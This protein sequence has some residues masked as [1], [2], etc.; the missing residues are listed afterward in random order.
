[1]DQ[2]GTRSPK[3]TSP[4]VWIILVI[5]VLAVAGGVL[6]ILSSGQE[7]ANNT[8]GATNANA[9]ANVNGTATNVDRANA[10]VGNTNTA[11]TNA[12]PYAGWEMYE[13][14]EVG[15]SLRYPHGWGIEEV[16]TRA[17]ALRSPG[18][19]PIQSG[20]VTFS[21]D[22]YIRVHY[23]PQNLSASDI[24]KSFNDSSA[25]WY[26][27]YPHQD[28]SLNGRTTLYF[29]AFQEEGQSY[30]RTD[31]FLPFDG[32]VIGVSYLFTEQTQ[33]ETVRAIASSISTDS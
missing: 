28:V 3:A 16:D 25:F 6:Y 14:A 21:H 1:M 4:V 18:Y 8:N 15:L 7:N 10:N 33:S 26:S 27:K 13:S 2:S 23:N 11:N 32:K 20:Q 5:V 9:V 31:Y 30:Q 22:I 12:D 24:I 17:V 29:P 19:Q